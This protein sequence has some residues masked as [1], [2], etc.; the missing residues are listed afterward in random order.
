[1]EP[2]LIE[3]P[4]LSVQELFDCAYDVGAHAEASF[5]LLA[6]PGLS[7]TAVAGL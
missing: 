1:M 7:S 5:P 6:P 3:Q 2:P 4:R